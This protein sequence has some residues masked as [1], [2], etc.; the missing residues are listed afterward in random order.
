MPFRFVRPPSLHVGQA[1]ASFRAN[2]DG[3]F[4]SG[5]T[6][7][8]LRLDGLTTPGTLFPLVLRS[9]QHRRSSTSSSSPGAASKLTGGHAF[10][11]TLKKT[12]TKAGNQDLA[13]RMVAFEIVVYCL[14]R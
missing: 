11:F 2:D 1:S 8:S 3:P 6:L 9:L 4:E 14:Q 12:K 5:L 10:D 7:S 13:L